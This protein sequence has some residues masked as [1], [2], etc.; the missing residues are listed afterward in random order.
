MP[1]INRTAR[2]CHFSSV[3]RANDIRVFHKECRTLAEAGF[4]VT[5]IA[6]D[7]EVSSPTVKII[8]LPNEGGRLQR[9][10][11]RAHTVYRLALAENADIYHFH[12][13]ELLPYA[14]RLKQKTG[15]KLVYDSHECYREDIVTKEWLPT[16]LRSL[17]AVTFGAF[18]RFVVPRLDLVVAAT[19]HIGRYFSQF[20]PNVATVNNYPMPE[21]FSQIVQKP[22]ELRDAFCYVGAIS[23]VRGIIPLLDALDDINPSVAFLLAGTFASEDV[24]RA[25]HEHRNWPRVTF[26]GQVGRDQVADVYNRS[27]AGVVTFLPAPNHINSQP[28]KLFEYMSAGIP[29]VCSNFDLWRSVVEAAGCGLCVDPGSGNAIASA[30]N[31][32]A[33]DAGIRERM[34]AQGRVMTLERFTWTNE[35]KILIDAYDQLAPKR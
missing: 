25:V 1:E 2:V 22:G 5:L 8:G 15:A 11:C 3:H 13:P 33:N 28:N 14:L 9:M 35:A 17:V 19:P 16:A 30:I 32:L 31:I 12:D 7:A 24:S 21:E 20:M 27:F 10:F 18:E 6:V 34:S 26:Y 23:F 29:V 4:A